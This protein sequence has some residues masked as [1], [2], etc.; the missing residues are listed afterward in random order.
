[1]NGQIECT[2]D[3]VHCVSYYRCTSEMK[4]DEHTRDFWLGEEAKTDEY[5]HIR[6]EREAIDAEIRTEVGCVEFPEEEEKYDIKKHGAVIGIRIYY[7]ND[8]IPMADIRTA[9]GFE[10]TIEWTC[11]TE[12]EEFQSGINGYTFFKDERPNNI[13]GEVE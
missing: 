2:T 12:R 8:H 9:F 13:F 1:M 10:N 6:E 3:C 5:E 7:I 11:P 4:L